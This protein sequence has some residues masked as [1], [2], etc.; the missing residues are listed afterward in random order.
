VRSIIS[1]AL[2]VT[3]LAG[4]VAAADK[5]TTSTPIRIDR[6][7]GIALDVR[8]DDGAPV[9][10]I[11]DTGSTRT[12]IADDLARA[13]GS[14][15]VATSLLTSSGG[16][17]RR[18]V[19][20]LSS[21]SVAEAKADDVLALVVPAGQLEAFGDGVRGLLGQ[22]FLSAF[23]YT[24]DYRR[25]R[26]TWYAAPDCGAPD[27]VALVASEGRYVMVLKDDRGRAL[28]L[29]PDTGADATVL[30]HAVEPFEAAAGGAVL[31]GLAGERPAQ[32]AIARRLRV[33]TTLLRDV[34]AVVVDR[35][36]PDV[37][38]L[39]PMHGF[40]SASFAAGGQCLSVRR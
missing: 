11:L 36:E 29:V 15:I 40:S 10:F 5:A 18:P 9:R 37:D 21:V 30:F 23:S 16:A 1:Q 20:R 13:L 28:R 34:P 8:I 25:R 38:G 22:D 39:M 12:V 33:G 32:R 19:V 35:P 6:R 3:V 4:T 7:G 26:L 2:L 24:I 31:G 27:A 14:T 17:E